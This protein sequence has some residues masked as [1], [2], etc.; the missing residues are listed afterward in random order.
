[1]LLEFNP[2]LKISIIVTCHNYEQYLQECLDSL[3]NQSRP[4]DEVII[5]NDSPK[6]AKAIDSI[7]TYSYKIINTNYSNPLLSRKRG[8]EESQFDYF[9]FLDADDQLEPD[10]ISNALNSLK[11]SDFVYSDLEQFGLFNNIIA[12]PNKIDPHTISLGNFCHI[13]CVTKKEYALNSNAFQHN[14]VNCHEDWA[15]WRKII[16]QNNLKITKQ[17]SKYLARIHKTNKSKQI[18]NLDYH[19]KRATTADDISIIVTGNTSHQERI[20]DNIAFPHNQINIIFSNSKPV[21]IASDFKSVQ[22]HNL[23][24]NAEQLLRWALKINS[25]LDSEF[26]LFFD[27]IRDIDIN[28][29]KHFGINA[30]LYVHKASYEFLRHTAIF[31]HPIK[32]IQDIKIPKLMA[33]NGIYV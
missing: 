6:N 21:S 9:C 2:A 22:F 8:L 29:I 26:I 10:Y 15:M 23:D 32:N 24:L 20:L 16:N 7:K 11:S 19:Q 4:P 3:F 13:G 17:E 30:G 1:M 27:N 25:S 5:V 14:H 33:L 12:Y 18:E 31:Y 28:M